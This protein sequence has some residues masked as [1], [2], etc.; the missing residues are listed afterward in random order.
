MKIRSEN[1]LTNE[2]SNRKIGNLFDLVLV[3]S[4]RTRAL[5]AGHQSKLNLANSNPVKALIEIEQGHVGQEYLY[6]KD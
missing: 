2:F 1:G 5:N 4:N 3:A 6:K